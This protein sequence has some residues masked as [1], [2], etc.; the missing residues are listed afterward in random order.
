[1]I[2]ACVL[3]LLLILLLPAFGVGSGAYLLIFLIFSFGL[4]VLMMSEH[5]GSHDHGSGKPGG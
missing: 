3:P 5:R 4:H 2:V 1:M